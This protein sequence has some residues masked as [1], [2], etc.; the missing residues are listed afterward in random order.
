MKSQLIKLNNESNGNKLFW[1]DVRKIRNQEK[2][3]CTNLKDGTERI[4]VNDE[5][6]FRRVVQRAQTRGDNCE[7]NWSWRCSE[8]CVGPI[9][10]QEVGNCE[11]AEEWEGD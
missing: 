1:E 4:L 3:V 7:Y 2:N 10:M 8:E 6:I 5:R 11:Y 9:K